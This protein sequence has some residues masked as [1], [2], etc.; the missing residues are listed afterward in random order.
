[1]TYY[2]A[3]KRDSFCS[4]VDR[5]YATLDECHTHAIETFGDGYTV[6]KITDAE[7]QAQLRYC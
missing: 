3:S 6:E 5:P 7:A 4:I 2:R 1:M